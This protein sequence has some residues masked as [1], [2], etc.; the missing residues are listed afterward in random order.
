M[1]L[2]RPHGQ[3]GRFSPPWATYQEWPWPAIPCDTLHR[4]GRYTGRPN[5]AVGAGLLL[6]AAVNADF[7]GNEREGARCVEIG[8]SVY[9]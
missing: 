2:D 4:N 7:I 3:G 9:Y 5:L 6:E 8:R 1:P